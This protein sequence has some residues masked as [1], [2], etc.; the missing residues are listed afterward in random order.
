M[1]N[2]IHH[3]GLTVF[4]RKNN[5]GLHH[6]A[7]KVAN[8]DALHDLHQTL[9]NTP[10]VVIEFA[11]EPLGGGTTHHIMCYIPGGIRVEFIALGA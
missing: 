5:I 11:P 7:L 4:D 9:Q 1:T 3:L 2:G 8:L 6:F 10:D